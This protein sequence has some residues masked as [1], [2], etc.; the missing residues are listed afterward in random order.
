MSIFK[1]RTRFREAAEILASE[2]FTENYIAELKKGLETAEHRSD[3]ALGKNYLI[4]AL[5]IRG[6]LTEACRLFEDI[7]L[8]RLDKSLHGNLISN[9]IFCKFVR[10]DFKAAD[11]LYKTYN[12]AV[13]GEHS[14]AMK[15]S[16]AIH[17]HING[18]YENSVEIIVKMGDSQ[19]RFIDIC[20]VKSLLRLDMYERAEEFA[21]DFDKYNDCD[22]L[23]VE[24]KKL[25]KKI[26]EKLYA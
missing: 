17:E 18:R 13:L 16:L 22:E 5:I 3:I 21:R 4:N 15:R 14:E 11:E 20:I 23:T 2:G 7:E 8:K 25:K 9:I 19:C 1:K 26:R 6:H 12:A 24:V 10:N